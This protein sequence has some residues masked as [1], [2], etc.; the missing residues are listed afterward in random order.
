MDFCGKI[1]SIYRLT[2][3]KILKNEYQNKGAMERDLVN[4]LVHYNTIRRH[5]S[6]KK[7]LKVETPLQVMVLLIWYIS[8]GFFHL[9]ID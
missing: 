4:F 5:R 1:G 3:V 6:F 8:N 7:E 9:I 2:M